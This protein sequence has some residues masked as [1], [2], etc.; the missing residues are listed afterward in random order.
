MLAWQP[1]PTPLC[2]KDAQ[3][4]L[5]TRVTLAVWRALAMVPGEH[6]LRRH[7]G[8]ALAVELGVSERY[9]RRLWEDVGDQLVCG[10]TLDLGVAVCSGWPLELTPT[11]MAAIHSISSDNRSFTERQVTM[12]MATKGLNYSTSTINRWLDD[13]G[14]MPNRCWIKPKLKSWQKVWR[15]GLCLQS[16]GP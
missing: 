4:S 7:I 10:H 12:K 6:K 3:V 9:M 16:R 13:M 11:K 1:L 15:I 5:N 8:L 2:R 14:A